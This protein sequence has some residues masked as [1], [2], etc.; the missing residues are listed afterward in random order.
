M[1]ALRTAAAVVV[2]AATTAI[3]AASALAWRLEV[4]GF[5]HPRDTAPRAAYLALLIVGVVVAVVA[6]ILVYR[7]AGIRS[8]PIP[9]LVVVGTLALSLSIGGFL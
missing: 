3:A 9:V 7:W 4:E 8:W 1:S 2:T 5:G 6:T